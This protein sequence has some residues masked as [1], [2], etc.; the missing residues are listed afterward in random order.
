M[1]KF[2]VLTAILTLIF[3]ACGGD[4]SKDNDSNEN[5]TLQIKNESSKAIDKVVFR[6]VSFMNEDADIIGT[7][8]GHNENTGND[9]FAYHTFTLNVANKTFTAVGVNSLTQDSCS[10]KWTRNG[11]S[12]TFNTDPPPW[13]GNGTGTLSGDTLSVTFGDAG[14]TNTFNLSSNN[15]QRSIQSGNSVTKP[16][17]AESGYIFFSIGSTN[18]RTSELKVV[19]KN[20]KA[21]FTFTNN[22]VVVKLSDNSTGSLGSL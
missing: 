18:Y 13:I 14:R 11:N 15:L 16:V 21:V 19:E 2:F 5:T 1:K 12:I 17:E 10:G 20:E 3:T 6:N 7:W 4:D 8:E 22:T 9:P